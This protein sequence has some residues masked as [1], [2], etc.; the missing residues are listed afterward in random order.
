MLTYI[1]KRIFL[2]IPTLL[3]VT[4]ITFAIGQLA[5]GDPA[6]LKAGGLSERADRGVTKKMIENIRKQWHMDEP[7]PVQYGYWVGNLVRLDFGKSLKDERPVIDKIWERIP[8]TLLMSFISILLAYLIAVPLG[9]YSATHP[10]TKTDKISTAILFMLY[11]LPSFW[12][13]TL[14]IIYLCR[15][16]GFIE[17]FPSAK[18]HSV[19][20]SPAWP[21]ADK[22]LDLLWH[23]ALP[24]IIYT[25]G[26]FAYI[27]R[28]MRGAMLETIRQ[29]YIRT[30]RAKGLSE[31][32]VVYK[33]AL[34]NSLIPIITLLAGL[35][36]S[37]IG[38]SVIVEQ[39]FSIP[40]MGQLAI[41]A[42]NERDYPL[43]MGELT[44]SAILTLFGVLLADLL[45]SVADP[46]ISLTKKG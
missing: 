9:I 1:F 46:R 15:G 41:Q 43:I 4:V 31:R 39:I 23:I 28:Q 14:G 35:L 19:D 25:Y 10:G 33:H 11:S 17:L 18:L 22:A 42:L 27:S 6:E 38:G 12:V 34:R 7:I 16:S 32:V 13:A 44:F 36:P 37:L 2:F 3:L 20:Y 26:S 40:G 29:D 5:P 8:I 21:F 30:A 45:Y 24:M